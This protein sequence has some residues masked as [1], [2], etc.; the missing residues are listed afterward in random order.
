MPTLT[1]PVASEVFLEHRGIRV[2]H[3]YRDEEFPER[4]QY[5]FSLSPD[6]EALEWQFDVR[7][8]PGGDESVSDPV[9][10]IRA[11]IDG[12]L[13]KGDDFPYVQEPG[14][15]PN[16]ADNTPQIDLPDDWDLLDLLLALRGR[17]Q[18]MTQPLDERHVAGAVQFIHTLSPHRRQLK[19]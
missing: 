10:V 13:D 19:G 17:T 8:L 18:P 1:L 12:C 7:E 9:T 5:L 3:C 16:E 6:E 15:L 14:P 4:Y 11:A 2:Y